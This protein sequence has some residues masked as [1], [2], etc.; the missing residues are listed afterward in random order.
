M[1]N[2]F[3][4]RSL[5]PTSADDGITAGSFEAY[6]VDEPGRN[7]TRIWLRVTLHQHRIRGQVDDLDA[8]IIA[9]V[10]D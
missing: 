6:Q 7:T 10:K 1:A 2:D 5:L 4:T 8:R 9:T 3:D